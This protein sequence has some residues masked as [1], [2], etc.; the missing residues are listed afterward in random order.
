VERVLDVKK[1]AEN[2]TVDVDYSNCELVPL[3]DE[4][5]TSDYTDNK[6]VCQNG[7][8]EPVVLVESMN[9]HITE[10]SDENINTILISQSKDYK[11]VYI[12]SHNWYTECCALN[13]YTYSL[14]NGGIEKLGNISSNSLGFLTGDIS[15]DGNKWAKFIYDPY[16]EG[17]ERLMVYD[18][19]SDSYH[20]VLVVDSETET[21]A[22]SCEL[23]CVSSL[24]WIDNKTLEYSIFDKTSVDSTLPNDFIEKRRIEI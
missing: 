23:T 14:E 7:K 11:E 16:L 4:Y 24:E 20:E 15:P 19:S 13:L 21:S 3:S 2:L 17:E 22:S 10:A 5:G 1:L 6:L 18:L 8:G 12:A 9:S